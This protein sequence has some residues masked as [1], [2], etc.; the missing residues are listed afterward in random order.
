MSKIPRPSAQ[1]DNH[2]GLLTHIQR[3][4]SSIG[5]EERIPEGILRKGQEQ[6]NVEVERGKESSKGN[7]KRNKWRE[8]I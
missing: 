8:V 7:G 1:Q 5:L 6:T 3:H 4:A 2:L